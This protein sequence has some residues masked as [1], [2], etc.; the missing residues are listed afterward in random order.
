MLGGVVVL[1]PIFAKDILHVGAVGLGF[2]R[3]APA[4]RRR[5]DGAVARQQ[6]L[7]A[8]AAPAAS[9]SRR[10]RVYGIATALFGWS[11]SFPLS[12]AAARR[13]RRIRHDQRRDPPHH[14]PGRDAGRAARPGRRRQLAVPVARPPSSS[15]FRAGAM[16][17]LIGAGPAVVIGGLMAAS[18]SRDS[19]RGCSRALPR[20]II[21]SSRRQTQRP[22]ARGH[23]GAKA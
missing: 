17:G 10:S 14:G 1:L 15:Q 12:L 6:R 3:A 23:E 19:G 18:L 9:C 22:A 2:L 16:A 7:R 4:A 11:T 21:W 8:S 5:A 20:A 13:R